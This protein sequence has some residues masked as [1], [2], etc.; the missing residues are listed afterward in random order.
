M[1]QNPKAHVAKTCVCI[2]TSFHL[3]KGKALGKVKSAFDSSGP[4]GLSLYPGFFSGLG[5]FLL[6]LDGMGFLSITGLPPPP[7][8]GIKFYRG[9]MGSVFHSNTMHYANAPPTDSFLLRSAPVPVA[10]IWSRFLHFF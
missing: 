6:P 1:P 7:T 3:G 8:P 2:Q 9:N 4:P 5:V 10:P